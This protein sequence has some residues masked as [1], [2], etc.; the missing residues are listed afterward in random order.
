MTTPNSFWQKKLKKR[1]EEILKAD[2]SIREFLHPSYTPHFINWK[3]VE[4]LFTRL[5]KQ[6]LSSKE[7]GSRLGIPVASMNRCLKKLRERGEINKKQD[8]FWNKKLNKTLT[9]YLEAGYVSEEIGKLL[10]FNRSFIS[11]KANFLGYTFDRK[12]KRWIKKQEKETE[13]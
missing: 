9:V 6:G 5:Y 11:Y 10:G 13:L 4:P 7:I 3:K 1:R 12:R 8:H 2:P